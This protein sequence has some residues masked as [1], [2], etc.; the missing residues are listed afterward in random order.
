LPLARHHAGARLRAGVEQR[1]APGLMVEMPARPG[2]DKAAA[3]LP[4][5]LDPLLRD[6]P[7]DEPEGV[8]RIRQQIMG[9]PILDLRRLAGEALADIDPAADRPAVA[10]AGAVTEL[11]RLE[12]GGVDAVLRQF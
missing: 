2:A 11:L 1:Q 7:L 10:R 3:L 9:A 6:Q 4:A 8:G 5:A 12:H